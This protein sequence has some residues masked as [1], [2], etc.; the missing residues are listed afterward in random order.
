MLWYLVKIYLVHV[1][2]LQFRDKYLKFVTVSS[3]HIVRDNQEPALIIA[4]GE[5][6]DLGLLG[7]LMEWTPFTVVL[8]GAMQRVLEAGIRC[9]VWL[10]DFDSGNEI[11]L[12]E[13]PH[14]SHIQKVHIEN[15]DLTDL[16]KGI[17]YLIQEGFTGVNIVWA[18]GKRQD[19]HLNNILTISKYS[20]RI[21]LNIIDDYSR[22][23]P[24]PNLYKKWYQKGTSI[25][26]I[27]VGE[28]TG[29]NTKNLRWNLSNERLFL[30]NFTSSSNE[31]LEDGFVEISFKDGHLLVMECWD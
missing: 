6:C 23:Y 13:Y 1:E 25:S 4:N 18:T 16:Q 21:S 2:T 7:D 29:V 17:E 9:D 10:G 22:I 20:E 12:Q 24:C 30:P 19:H 3:H 8:D 14:L 26:L 28:A 11:N 31:V 27:P 5:S 15:Q